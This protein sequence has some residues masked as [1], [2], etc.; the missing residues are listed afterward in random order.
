MPFQLPPFHAL[1]LQ[2]DGPPLNAW[3]LFGD[4]DELGRANLIDA[5]AVKRGLEAAKE[6]IVVNLKYASLSRVQVRN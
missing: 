2:K 6:G 1:P 3:G 5:A 4:D